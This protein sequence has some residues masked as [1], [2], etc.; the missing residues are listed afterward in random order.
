[1][2]LKERQKMTVTKQRYK[3]GSTFHRPGKPSYIT[4]DLTIQVESREAHTQKHVPGS[5]KCHEEVP[6]KQ[7]RR[8][9]EDKDE[10]H[11]AEVCWIYSQA[12]QGLLR[13]ET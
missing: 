11:A 6:S 3:S 5:S 4:V 13:T 8:S 10:A 12:P 7:L 2:P 9:R 1:M